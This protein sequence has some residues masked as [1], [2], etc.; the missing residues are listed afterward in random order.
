VSESDSDKEDLSSQPAYGT[1]Q[2]TEGA[3]TT[4]ERNLPNRAAK[5]KARMKEA[6]KRNRQ[7]KKAKAHS[8]HQL[9]ELRHVRNAE[10][11]A[12]TYSGDNFNISARGYIGKADHGDEKTYSLHEMVGEGSKFKFALKKW[13]G[14]SVRIKFSEE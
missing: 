6:S 13:D 8:E 9:R 7:K 3:G 5:R 12:S 4:T 2:Q 1:C 14:R 10:P 11:V